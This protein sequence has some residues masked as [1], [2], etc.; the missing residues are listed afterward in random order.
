MAAVRVVEGVEIPE[1]L[2][3][4]EAQHHPSETPA[5][6]REAAARALAIKALLLNRAAE[7]GLAPCPERDEAGRE[8]APEEALVRQVLAA[9][10]DSSRPT[11]AECLRFYEARRASG[12][13]MRSFAAERRRIGDHLQRRA[14]AGAAA[15][16]VGDLAERARA[17]GVAIRLDDAGAAPSRL[18][19]LGAL[20]SDGAAAARLPAW[21]EA[22]DPAL[23]ERLTERARADGVAVG[24]AVRRAAADF[25]ST[26]D[27]A[28]WTKLVT[29]MR[30]ADDPALAGLAQIV[31]ERLVP[32]P[33]TFTLVRRRA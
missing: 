13:A 26:A 1:R 27:D 15:R 2:I 6:A 31:K 17:A 8:E 20:L 7:L 21:L 11:E 33:R 10:V 30:E 4:E 28:A 9:E 24:E 25:V 12:H 16:Y 19:S 14:W 23:A 18:I 32:P 5:E 29:A 22:A 3:A